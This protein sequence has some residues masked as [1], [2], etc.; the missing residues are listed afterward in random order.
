LGKEWRLERKRRRI[1]N[2]LSVSGSKDKAAAS[3]N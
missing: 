3:G 1:S 2:R